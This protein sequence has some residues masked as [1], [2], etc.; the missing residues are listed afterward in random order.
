MVVEELVE[1]RF[2]IEWEDK[3]EDDSQSYITP[4]NPMVV[5]ASSSAMKRETG[6]AKAIAEMAWDYV[7]N[8][9]DYKLSKLWK[10]PETTLLDKEGD[11]EDV[12]FLIASMLPNMGVKRS[13]IVIGDMVFPDGSETLHVWNEVDGHVIDATGSKESRDL[14][15]YK[16]KTTYVI[17]A[18]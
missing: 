11:C 3:F 18:E 14:A 16:A 8:N 7:Y 5:D 1:E 10:V 13:K 12:T 2:W 4:G 17:V 9:I 6:D 15:E